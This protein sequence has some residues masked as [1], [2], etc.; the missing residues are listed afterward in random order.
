MECMLES[1]Y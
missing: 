1:T